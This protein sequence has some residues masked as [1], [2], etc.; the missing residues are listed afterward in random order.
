MSVSLLKSR[1]GVYYLRLIHPNGI[2]SSR[3][4]T[5]ISLRTKDRKVA[6]SIVAERLLHIASSATDRIGNRRTQVK[7]TFADGHL[8]EQAGSDVGLISAERRPSAH[9]DE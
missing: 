1:H 6:A 7:A 9:G 2:A 3:R 8:G 5:R 4:E